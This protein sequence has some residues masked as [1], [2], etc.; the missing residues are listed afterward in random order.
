MV[1]GKADM[2]DCGRVAL[3][4]VDRK[5]EEIRKATGVPV[6]GVRFV[7]DAVFP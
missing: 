1:F 2:V 4:S 7:E 5:A 6:A 3:S